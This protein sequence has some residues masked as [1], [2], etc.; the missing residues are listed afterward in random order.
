MKVL[1]LTLLCCFPLMISQA[2]ESAFPKTEVDTIE[3]KT[4]PASK[5]ILSRTRGDYFDS[6]NNLFG[7]LFRYIQK[8]NIAMTTPV[9]AE[10][11]PGVMYFYIGG[12]AAE[13]EFEP[14]DQV[15]VKDLPTRTVASI[16]IRGGYNEARYLAAKQRL[17]QWLANQ[18]QYQVSGTARAIYW[19]GPFTPSIF[20]RA[21]VHIPV[22]TTE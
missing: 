1:V 3:I 2:Y 10:I 11:S 20:K 15:E 5:V 14:T 19:N 4:I 8:N 18:T 7:S 16:G 12:A 9:E 21:E 17:E 6:N 13:R 22:T